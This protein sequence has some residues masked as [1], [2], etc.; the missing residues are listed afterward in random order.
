VSTIKETPKRL[1]CRL[2][3]KGKKKEKKAADRGK[4]AG[5]KENRIRA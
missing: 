2:R 3:H 4:E 1:F 5:R